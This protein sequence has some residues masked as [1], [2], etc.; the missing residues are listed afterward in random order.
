MDQD[1]PEI[2]AAEQTAQKLRIF[3]SYGHRDHVEKVMF[4]KKALEARGHT[5]WIDEKDIR[6]GNDW[7]RNILQGIRDSQMVLAFLSKYSMRDPGVCRDELQ[8][9]IGCKG[10]NIKTVLLEPVDKICPP[11]TLS[12]SQ[13]LDIS[14]W[15]GSEA[16]GQLI[17][18]K[19][20]RMVETRENFI[21]DDEIDMLRQILNPVSCESRI[22]ELCS[23]KMFGRQWLYEKLLDWDTNAQSKLFYL[24]GGA[25]F[26]KSMFSANLCTYLCDKV[27]AA[28]FIEWDKASFYEPAAILKNLAYQLAK[29]YPDYR[30]FIVNLP[31][32]T[33]DK[34]C[35]SPEEGGFS[36]DELCDIFFCEQAGL[37]ID[38]EHPTAWVVLDALDEATKNGKNIIAKTI[39]RHLDRFPG[40]LKFIITSR[41]DDAVRSALQSFRP[42]IYDVDRGVRENQRN[43]MR[44][45][46]QAE[47]EGYNF[48]EKALNSLIDKSDGMFLYLRFACE[49]IIAEKLTEKEIMAFPQGIAG[50]YS[51]YFERQFGGGNY[52]IFEDDVRPVLEL[53]RSACESLSLDLLAEMLEW[54][55]EKLQCGIARLGTLKVDR[56][57]KGVQYF[58]LCHKSIWDWLEQQKPGLYS[59]RISRENGQKKIVDFCLKKIGEYKMDQLTKDSQYNYPLRHVISHLIELKNE[60]EIWK[61]LGGVEPVL[62]RIQYDFF[63]NHAA[64]IDSYRKAVKFY[65]DLYQ[66][67]HKPQIFPKLCRL[68]VT[69]QKLFAEQQGQ[70]RNVFD[71]DNT[72]KKAFEIMEGIRDVKT[73]FVI[74]C[75]LLGLAEKR[76]WNKDELIDI[77]VKH[78][79]DDIDELDRDC[80]EF[81]ANGPLADVLSGLTAPQLIK[82]LAIIANNYCRK[83]LLETLFERRSDP[84]ITQAKWYFDKLDEV[85]RGQ[86]GAKEDFETEKSDILALEDADERCEK[87]RDLAVKLYVAGRS[88]EAFQLLEE[89]EKELPETNSWQVEEVSEIRYFVG[90]NDKAARCLLNNQKLYDFARELFEFVSLLCKYSFT[91]EAYEYFETHILPDSEA[92]AKSFEEYAKTASVIQCLLEQENSVL[93]KKLQQDPETLIEFLPKLNWEKF[94]DTL[95]KKSQLATAFDVFQ[96]AL[97]KSENKEKLLQDPRFAPILEKFKAAGLWQGELPCVGKELETHQLSTFEECFE[98]RSDFLRSS[99]PV[100]IQ[101]EYITAAWNLFKTELADG[102]IQDDTEKKRDL[103]NKIRRILT[104]NSS[105]LRERITPF[106]KELLVLLADAPIETATDLTEAWFNGRDTL[107]K[108]TLKKEDIAGYASVFA[109]KMFEASAECDTKDGFKCL[110]SHYVFENELEAMQVLLEKMD[111]PP[112][113]KCEF[114][115]DTLDSTNRYLLSD[116]DRNTAAVPEHY[117]AVIKLAAPFCNGLVLD[118]LPCWDITSV[119]D[120]LYLYK[121]QQS[122]VSAGKAIFEILDPMVS[123]SKADNRDVADF[124]KA[125]SW[126]IDAKQFEAWFAKLIPTSK[127]RRN[128]R[129]ENSALN[130]QIDVFLTYVEKTDTE[131][132]EW[133]DHALAQIKSLNDARDKNKRLIQLFKVAMVKGTKEQTETALACIGNAVLIANSHEFNEVDILKLYSFLCN[134]HVSDSAVRNIISDQSWGE[135]PLEKLGVLSVHLL[136][137]DEYVKKWFAALQKEL[138]ESRNA[139]VLTE[140]ITACPEL[141]L[142]SLCEQKEEA[143]S[144]EGPALTPEKLEQLY[145]TLITCPKCSSRIPK[146]KFCPEC[147]SPLAAVCPDCGQAITPGA[148]FCPECGRKLI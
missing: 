58:Q 24:V 55:A 65:F 7:R 80:A 110:F 107:L 15:D 53:C 94:V 20:V 115:F 27:V 126:L 127:G 45:Y 49:S 84:Q 130:E 142:S 1:S 79:G 141:G 90:Q 74:G 86:L 77:I 104:C 83:R 22:K 147:G 113:E 81:L 108:D 26:G 85:N 9:S 21:F 145:E 75:Y 30:K 18:A 3:F 28:Q 123:R 31:I 114:I 136:D 52:R 91:K 38:G 144:P 17:I 64:A 13:W 35:R 33:R 101:M 119:L 2:T 50:I 122:A 42:D 51:G 60:P 96:T 8:I 66:E 71:Q 131:V 37:C 14:C 88:E 44:E 68:I 125:C 87:R 82:L 48:S 23:K 76:K 89:A 61:L 70:L 25:G 47:L 93:L 148:K 118:D 12:Q 56:E 143:V 135:L 102:E 146:K 57:E 5:V 73:Y 29:R 120:E 112:K 106:V 36:E 133:F 129:R 128:S 6:H 72:L 54:S 34:L 105:E 40:W 19:I 69:Y 41:D 39:A 121:A 43:D 124:L 92:C 46:L 98:Q 140:I 116:K 67:T 10:G 95:E 109:Q 111:L 78:C 99:V 117:E 137:S 138:I 32:Q 132:K 62:P 134:S 100:H 59:F 97:K 103:F 139:A 11:A 16:E 63:E 4:I